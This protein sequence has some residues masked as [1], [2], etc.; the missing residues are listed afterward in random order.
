MNAETCGTLQGKIVFVLILYIHKYDVK[1]ARSQGKTRPREREYE[2]I[3]TSR[4]D[5]ALLNIE[6]LLRCR[7]MVRKPAKETSYLHQ[8]FCPQRH[9][10]DTGARHEENTIFSSNSSS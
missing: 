1:V 2:S 6:M 3:W 8:V 4:M 5:A 9:P 7:V 10:R